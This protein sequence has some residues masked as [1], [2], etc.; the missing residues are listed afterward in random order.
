MTTFVQGTLLQLPGSDQRPR[1]I[2]RH[3][4]KLQQ[5]GSRSCWT[6]SR[7]IECCRLGRRKTS[8]M[9]SKMKGKQKT[10]SQV[11]YKRLK[12]K[13]VRK[14]YAKVDV[15][16]RICKSIKIINSINTSTVIEV[17]VLSL[18]LPAM[19]TIEWSNKAA[20]IQAVSRKWLRMVET[21]CSQRPV[22][23]GI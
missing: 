18:V 7:R 14:G 21:P 16:G 13:T 2:W 6:R 17:N 1:F 8:D 9:Y 12:N 10:V 3:L 20:T 4:G 15:E 23:V 5:R 19:Q 11:F 22:V